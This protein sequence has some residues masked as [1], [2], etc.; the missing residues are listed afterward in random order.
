MCHSQEVYMGSTSLRICIE[1]L[2]QVGQYF[3]ATS[4]PQCW[5]HTHACSHMR[6]TWLLT[7]VMI[8]FRCSGTMHTLPHSWFKT[9]CT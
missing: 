2:L 5:S 7:P 3:G 9:Q 8:P 6:A 4:E 1:L